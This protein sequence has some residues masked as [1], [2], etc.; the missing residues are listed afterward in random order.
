MRKVKQAPETLSHPNGPETAA[1]AMITH[2]EQ[3]FN[4]STAESSSHPLLI[5]NTDTPSPFTSDQVKAVIKKLHPRK[6]PGIDHITGAMLKPIVS[7]L[8][9]VL[10]SYFTLCWLWS[11]TPKDWRIAQV[12]PIFKKGDPTVAANYRPISLTSIFRE[13]F[14]YRYALHV[15][16]TSKRY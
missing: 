1:E 9:P 13:A 4:G 16:S 10:A 5:D 2:L 12:V 15:W 11:W 3:V 8:A 6:A 7:Q 14:L